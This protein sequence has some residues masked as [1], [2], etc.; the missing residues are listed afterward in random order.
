ML[1]RSVILLGIVL[2]LGMTGCTKAAGDAPV[3]V[4]E[5]TSEEKEAMTPVESSGSEEGSGETGVPAGAE[6]GSV[7]T[8]VPAGAEAGTDTGSELMGYFGEDISRAKEAFSSMEE[9]GEYENLAL[10]MDKEEEYDGVLA[11]PE[12]SVDSDLQIVGIAYSGKK[13]TLAGLST[14]MTMQDAM[15]S[16]KGEGWTLSDV[17]FAHGTAQYVVSFDKDSQT[18]SIVSTDEGEFGKTEESD[19]TGN[20]ER[21][22][23]V[24]K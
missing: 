15:G 3:T 6:E 5:E 8:G 16:L 24:K 18:L 9:M 23:V 2:L 14:A 22:S 21:I 12:F 11:G 19:V 17:D 7:E 13:Y 1:R 4:P 20:V 10:Y